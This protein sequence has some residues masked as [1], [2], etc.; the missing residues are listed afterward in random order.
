MVGESSYKMIETSCL[1]MVFKC[2]KFMLTDN[3]DLFIQY[4]VNIISALVILIYW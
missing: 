1:W 3:S 2:S 4:A